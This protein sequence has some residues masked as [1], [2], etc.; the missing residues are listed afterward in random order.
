MQQLERNEIELADF[1]GHHGRPALLQKHRD[2]SKG[3]KAPCIF[4]SLSHFD[5]GQ[6]FLVDS[7]HNV[8]LGAF[9]SASHPILW[10]CTLRVAFQKKLL[11]LWLSHQHR[12]ETWSIYTRM[13][14]LS[15]ALSRFRFPSTTT[16]IPRSLHKFTKIQRQW[17][18]RR[19]VVWIFDIRTL[20]QTWV[21]FTS[22]FTSARDALRKMHVTTG[23][24]TVRL[25]M[26]LLFI[27]RISVAHWWHG[28][29]GPTTV[30]LLF[31]WFSDSIHETTQCAGNSCFPV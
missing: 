23:R 1:N 11:S 21:L 2:L 14:E 16:R 24:E 27:G 28:R 19:I 6:S 31:D 22:S 17:I 9:V 15:L 7:L 20:T 4:R 26:F 8:Y 10:N 25:A 12:D 30:L 5:V 13:N 18:S 3:L 29:E